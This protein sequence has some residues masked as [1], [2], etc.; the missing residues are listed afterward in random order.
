MKAE[1]M[2]YL[3]D[4]GSISTLDTCCKCFVTRKNLLVVLTKKPDRSHKFGDVK[5]SYCIHLTH[6]Q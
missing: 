2:M 5:E 6:R 3:A 4:M 1:K